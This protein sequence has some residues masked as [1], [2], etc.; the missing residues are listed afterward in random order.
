MKAVVIGG[1]GF[2]GGAIVRQLVAR[3][4]ETAVIGRHRYPEVDR[5]GATCICGDIRDTA[6]LTSNLRGFDTVFHVAAKAG[7]WG[8]REEYESIN[9]VGTENVIAACLANGVENMVYTSTPSVV[10]SGGDIQGGDEFLP[11]AGK[12]LCHYAA[13]KA[14]AERLV[15]AA[16]A[17]GLKTCA[18]RPHLVWGPGD[19]HLLPRLIER[20]RKKQLRQV[21]DGSNLVDIS[22]VENV[23]TAHVLAAENLRTVASGAGNAYFISQ[24][25]PV[26]LWTWINDLFR[27]LAIPPVTKRVSFGMAYLA[28]ASLEAA[29]TVLGKKEE[30][31]MTRFL[32]EQ[33]AKSHWFS[34]AAARRDL[35]YE[36]QVSTAEGMNRL[37]AWL[38][39]DRRTFPL[40]QRMISE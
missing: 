1:G 39:E 4:D 10:F 28:G 3:G 31:I 6:F 29:H 2:V 19:P 36:P 30:P 5:L 33:L 24:G 16:N 22:Y 7:I 23:A 18:I 8:E 15:L 21:G 26:R 12:F 32:A 37:V 9:V 40:P 34:I 17:A 38:A 14:R 13:T 25:E 11:Y 20:G 35:G 27:R